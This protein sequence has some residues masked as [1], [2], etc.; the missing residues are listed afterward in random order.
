MKV[1]LLLACALASPSAPDVAGS[2][3]LEAWL[4]SFTLPPSPPLR[5]K[6]SSN[7]R[8]KV[9]LSKHRYSSFCA[10]LAVSTSVAFI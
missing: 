8:A 10:A 2:T 3:N 4:A 5:E 6:V 1:A 9:S 7:N